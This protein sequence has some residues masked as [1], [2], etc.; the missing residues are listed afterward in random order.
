MASAGPRADGACVRGELDEGNPARGE[1]RQPRAGGR[2]PAR[3][4][5]RVVPRA[6]AREATWRHPAT[7]ARVTCTEPERAIAG[8]RAGSAARARSAKRFSVGRGEADPRLGATVDVAHAHGPAVRVGDGGHDREA[9]SGAVRDRAPREPLGAVLEHLAGEP[10]AAV[11][12]DEVDPSA[13]RPR[14]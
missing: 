4:R 2:G 3:A 10:V 5:G 1:G 14:L 9:E 6:G 7:V 11:A 12:D 13:V 8:F